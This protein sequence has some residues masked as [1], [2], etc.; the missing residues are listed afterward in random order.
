MFTWPSTGPRTTTAK[1]PDV[2]RQIILGAAMMRFHAGGFGA[3]TLD[4]VLEGTGV[5]KGALY[6]HFP[7]K[8]ALGYAVVD[9]V[10]RGWIL[11]NWVEPLSRADD[12]LEALKR[13]VRTALE[14]TPEDF[15]ALGCPLNNL[16][17]EMS[18]VD[19]GFRRRFERIYEEW[20]GGIA[21]VLRRGQAA[22]YVRDDIDPAGT[23]ALMVA[24]VEGMAGT[25]KA[26]RSKALAAPLVAA[27]CQLIDGLRPAAAAREVVVS[28]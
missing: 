27:F 21:E 5:T 4:Q 1:Q 24:T 12:P 2:T 19:E 9:E 16:T 20:R 25:F 18:S 26:A 28:G 6:H 17:Q 8:Q 22:G 10:I 11:V 13:V 23:G 14:E 7:N 3:T 15:L